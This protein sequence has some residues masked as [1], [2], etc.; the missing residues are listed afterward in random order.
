MKQ[1]RTVPQS[2]LSNKTKLSERVRPDC[3]AAPWVIKEIKKL[4]SELELAQLF[5]QVAVKERDLARLK[6]ET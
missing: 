3:E 4:E 5:H 1:T 2:P 6:A